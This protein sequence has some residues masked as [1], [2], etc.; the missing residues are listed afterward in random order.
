MSLQLLLIGTS[1]LKCYHCGGLASVSCDEF[2]KAADKTTYE[3]EC[4]A[5]NKAIGALLTETCQIT[6]VGKL[7]LLPLPIN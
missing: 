3:N 5:I 4:A 2:D 1:G 6:T 7:A